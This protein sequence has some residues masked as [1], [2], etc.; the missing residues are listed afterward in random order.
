MKNC[1]FSAGK[2]LTTSAEDSASFKEQLESQEASRKYSYGSNF[3]VTVAFTLPQDEV[4]DIF[5]SVAS[6]K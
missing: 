2:T 6:N 4:I 3:E 5:E 1:D